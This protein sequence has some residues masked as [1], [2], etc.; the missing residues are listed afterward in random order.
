MTPRPNTTYFKLQTEGNYF[1]P[2]N[3]LRIP[4]RFK[5]LLLPKHMRIL[6]PNGGKNRDEIQNNTPSYSNRG[7]QQGRERHRGLRKCQGRKEKTES[8][9]TPWNLKRCNPRSKP[10]TSVPIHTGQTNLTR[11]TSKPNQRRSN[12]KK[13]LRRTTE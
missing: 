5:H 7:L 12:E 3:N 13:T 6:N 4:Q 1:R 2:Y 11:L 10:R 8:T 9:R